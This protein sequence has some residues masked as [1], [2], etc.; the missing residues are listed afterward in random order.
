MQKPFDI[1]KEL[2]WDAYKKVKRNQGAAGVDGVSLKEFESHLE[3]N[4]Y[5]LWNRMSSGSYFPP[6]V[7]LVEIPKKDGSV[8]PLGIP[9]VADRIAQTAVKEILEPKVE[10]C[11]HKDSYGYR[12]KKSAHQALEVVRQRCWRYDWVLDVDIKGFFD[13]LDHELL[14]KALVKHCDSKW[15]LLY[16][17]RWLKAP[18]E[19]ENGKQLE[20][21]KGTP[22]GGV[23][24]PLLANLFLHYA[25]DEW[26]RR[27][28]PHSLFERYADDILVHCK[29]KEE[30]ENLKAVIAQ[31]LLECKLE[32]HPEK[33]KIVYCKDGKRRDDYP[34]RKFDYL[35]YTFRPRLV[36]DSRGEYFVS[37]TPAISQEARTAIRRAMRRWRFDRRSDLSLDELAERINPK[38]RGWINYYGVYR[39]SELRLVFQALNRTLVRWARKKYKKMRYSQA[40][41]MAW[42]REIAKSQRTL[43]YHWQVDILPVFER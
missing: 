2:I 4:L 38:L 24:S 39:R 32:L 21:G 43:F 31:R 20:R 10:T 3:D 41:A 30:A 33:T 13:N 16:I 26:M 37:F 19:L 22:Q 36:R 29:A 7:R 23:I 17:E 1:P 11:F 8:R 42:L 25:F 40:R 28:Y 15:I 14:M 27:K 18:I 35:G 9:T 12:P 34:T 5:K 6:A